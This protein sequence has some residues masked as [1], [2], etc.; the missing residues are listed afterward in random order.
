MQSEDDKITCESW[1]TVPTK[2]RGGQNPPHTVQR[3]DKQLWNGN[4]AR[5]QI[6]E[7]AM[8]GFYRYSY[9]IPGNPYVIITGVAP[10]AHQSL[11]EELAC[12]LTEDP[13]IKALH[14]AHGDSICVLRR[15]E[16]S[17][18]STLHEDLRELYKTHK[19]PVYL[20]KIGHKGT[21]SMFDLTSEV[22]VGLYYSTQRPADMEQLRKKIVEI[23]ASI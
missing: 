8:N 7:T 9:R 17:A 5:I 10:L 12:V 19:H 6:G 21:I 14:E 11:S 13:S 23:L 2:R 20:I 22:N 18:H 16:T 15:P 4:G 1:V 3:P